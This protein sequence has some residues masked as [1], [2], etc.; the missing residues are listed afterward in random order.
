VLYNYAKR[1]LQSFDAL[2]NQ[3]KELKHDVSGTFRLAT[4]YSIGLHEIPPY[5]KRFMQ[6][7]PAVNIRVEYRRANQVYDDLIGNVVDLGL[8]AYPPRDSRL[9][10]VPLRKDR[11][12]LVAHP[13]NPLAA[14]KSIK[15]KALNGQK[16]VS[17]EPD[18][19][20]RKALDKLFK[21]LGV[22]V[23]HVMQFDN[24]ETVKGAVEVD[25]G[26]AILPEETV[27]EEVAR[28]TLVAVPLE[29]SYYR[30]VG[31]VYKKGKVLSPAMKGFIEL[32]K[33]QL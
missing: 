13:Q 7:H 23:Q 27:E 20:T 19:P 26:V 8:V 29:G 15:L 25:A 5:I 11:L 16:L 24:V 21:D 28:R 33:K 31:A 22:T 14:L 4:V 12:V 30:E 6:E 3:V 9:E 2:Q 1:I 18:M 32:L 17:F 10:T